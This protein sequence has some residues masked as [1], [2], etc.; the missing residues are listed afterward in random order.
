MLDRNTLDTKVTWSTTN[1]L[2]V[3][4]RF[5]VLHFYTTNGTVF[6]DQ[7]QGQAMGSS[8]PGTGNGN[9]YN[10]S[11]GATYAI[12]VTNPK[13]LNFGVKSMVVDGKS[14]QGNVVP[15]YADGKTHEV[16]VVLGA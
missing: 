8:N 9:T 13:G 15:A 4:G 12:E 10:I 3:F 5:S 11:G 7:L 6:G 14:I 16:K 1:R 2:N